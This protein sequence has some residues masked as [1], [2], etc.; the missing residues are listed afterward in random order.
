MSDVEPPTPDAGHNLPPIGKL[1]DEM[2]HHAGLWSRNAGQGE[3]HR[4]VIMAHAFSLRSHMEDPQLRVLIKGV[5][6]EAEIRVT[7]RSG[8]FTPLLHFA[9]HKA[10]IKPEKSQISRWA[11]ALQYAWTFDPR[12]APETVV[13]WIKSH[14]GDVECA[15]RARKGAG[16][17]TDNPATPI[18]LP[19]DLPAELFGDGMSGRIERAPDGGWQFVPRNPKAVSSETTQ[20]ADAQPATA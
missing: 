18:P 6:A 1:A 20:G 2:K 7:K 15:K 4:Y 10:E 17:G 12:P 14:G 19:C 16:A 13:D 9:F 8:E 5:L 11:G 3:K